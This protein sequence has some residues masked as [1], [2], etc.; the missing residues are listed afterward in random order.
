MTALN[1]AL[2]IGALLLQ[3]AEL[4]RSR[5]AVTLLAGSG[6]ARELVCG[7]V[8]GKITHGAAAAEADAGNT[9]DGA[10]GAITLGALAEIGDYKLKCLVAGS[11]TPGVATE[12]H[13]GNTGDGAMGAITVGDQ[14]QVGD[15]VL[16]CIEAAANAGVFQVVAPNGYRLPDLTVGVAYAGDHLSMTLADGDNDFI[17]GDKFT[18]TVA[19]VDAN[20]GLFQVVSPSGYVLPPLTVGVA[21]AGDHLNMTLADGDTD[22]AVGDL[23][24]ITVAAGSGK[25]APLTPAAVDGSQNAAGVLLFPVTVPDGADKLGV[26]L[27]ADAVVRLGALTW[28]DGITAGQKAAALAQLKAL[29]IAAREEV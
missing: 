10:M 19:P 8:L 16:T 26:A 29:G 23:I 12:D 25:W 15:Y 6:A 14:A 28:P 1:E 17:V 3:E 22:F 2:N 5:E 13:A 20:V 7:Q 27:V 9:G 4:R 11:P 24:T 18:I 21:Y